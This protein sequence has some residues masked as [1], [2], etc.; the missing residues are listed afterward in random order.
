MREL[1]APS[2]LNAAL[3]RR[4]LPEVSALTPAIANVLGGE[5]G[6]VIDST[7]IAGAAR[8]SSS[9]LFVLC[10][11]AAVVLRLLR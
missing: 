9:P 7:P 1:L 5:R 10:A 6:I 11:L 3:S 8:C 2:A 4:G